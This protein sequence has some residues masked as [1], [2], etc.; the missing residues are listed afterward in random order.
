M[1]AIIFAKFAKIGIESADFLQK[2][3]QKSRCLQRKLQYFAKD[4]Q[5]CKN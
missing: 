5:F 2:S 3:L 4:L 1:F